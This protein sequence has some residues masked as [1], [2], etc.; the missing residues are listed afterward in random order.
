[1]GAAA[2]PLPIYAAYTMGEKCKYVET[3]PS[4]SNGVTMHSEQGSNYSV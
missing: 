1:M 4:I 3:G 2:Y